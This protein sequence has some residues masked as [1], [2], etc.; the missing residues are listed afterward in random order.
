MVPGNDP[1][2]AVEQQAK[3]AGTTLPYHGHVQ[4]NVSRGPSDNPLEHVPNVIGKNLQDAISA[5]QAT[6]LRLLY[7]RLPITSRTQAG[8]IVQQSPLVGANAP[9]NAQILVF[10][11]AYRPNH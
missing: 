7:V 2:G 4:I 3:P 11:G 5:L 1:L 8:T 9:Q 6:K 10:L